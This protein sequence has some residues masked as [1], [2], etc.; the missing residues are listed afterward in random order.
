MIIAS[1]K[2][3]ST[4]VE[5]LC[6]SFDT[7][8]SV[9]YVIKQDKIRKKRMKSLMAYSF[10]LCL[11]YGKI[12]L[13]DERNACALTLFPDQQ[14]TNI[15][16][17]IKLIFECIGL[18][19]VMKVLKRNS[20]IK[21]FYPQQ[22]IIYLW[23]IGVNSKEQNKGIGSKLLLEIIKDSESKQ[24]PIYLETSMPENLPFYQKFGFTI[25]RK[26]DF[27]HKLYLLKRN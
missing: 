2:D 24:K 19:R 7:N 27:G 18:T 15:C 16:L 8:N 23:F 10:E 20:Q 13:N 3:K 6:Q 22:P 14:K 9:N 11:R 5:I 17:D 4:V 26:L 12:Y 21:K 25:Y 1:S